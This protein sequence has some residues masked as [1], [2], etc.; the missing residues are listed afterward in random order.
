MLKV[1]ITAAL[2]ALSTCPSWAQSNPSSG[3]KSED[4]SKAAET[5]QQL[6]SSTEI[7]KQLLSEAQC[8]GVIPKMT[9]GGFIAGAEHGSGLVSCRNGQNWSAPAFFGISGGS[10]GLQAGLE[11]SQIVLLMNQQGRDYLMKGNFQLGA[12]AVAAGPTGGASGSVGWKAPIMTYAKSK[13]A[14]AGVNL[15]GSTIKF[16]DSNNKKVYGSNAEPQQ[17]LNG[18]VQPPPQAQPFISALQSATQHS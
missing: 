13:G 9:K 17:L 2:F 18:S 7:P 5:L 11:N 6:T 15:A 1:A 4:F 16:D 10:V 8:I 3:A 14:Y 12:E